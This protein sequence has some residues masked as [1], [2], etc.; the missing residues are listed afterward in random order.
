MSSTQQPPVTTIL[1]GS[2]YRTLLSLHSSTGEHC[3]QNL[4][5][6]GAQ[7][8]EKKN[9]FNFKLGQNTKNS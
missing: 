4:G 6:Q 3:L 7:P 8:G 1:E 9:N 2:E 5:G